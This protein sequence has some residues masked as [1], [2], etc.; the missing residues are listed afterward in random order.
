MKNN[1][2]ETITESCSFCGS[3]DFIHHS[4][5]TYWTIVELNFTECS[6]CGLIFA[7]P[8]PTLETI[9]KG[10]DAL[11]VVMKS[12]GT[13]SQYRGGKEF[14]FYLKKLKPSGILLDVGCAEGFFLKGIEDNSEWKVEGID[15]IK[16][17]VDFANQKL[18]I[19]TYFGTLESLKDCIGKYD[20]VRM[21]NIIEHVQNPVTF[22][23]KT[24]E[25]MKTGGLVLCSTPNGVQDGYLLK[26]ANKQGTILNLLENHFH[27]YKPKTLK[28]IFESC[29]FKIEK[30]YCDGFKHSLKE[31]GYL[32]WLNIKGGFQ[33]YN[34]NDYEKSLNEEYS[35]MEVLISELKSHPSVKTY[36]IKFNVFVNR[37]SKLK[38]NS[39]IPVGHQ[40]TIIASKLRDL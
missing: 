16:S 27:Y 18:N 33:K 4:K 29:G 24:N 36:K 17:A 38:I 12:R 3:G 39:K 10:N 6:N 31:F 14:T 15:L 22:L 26:S 25:I 11:N 20:F 32:P 19:R 40:Q 13:I 1:Y 5:A 34:L 23:L 2:Y 8:M 35:D 7:N 28:T 37:L 30:A 9:I 21:N